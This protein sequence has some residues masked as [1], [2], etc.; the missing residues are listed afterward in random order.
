MV[1]FFGGS[2]LGVIQ[3]RRHDFESGGR[4]PVKPGRIFDAHSL[5][6][7]PVFSD[8][9]RILGG[10]R[11]GVSSAAG[12][13]RLLFLRAEALVFRWSLEAAK[14]YAQ[15]DCTNLVRC[16]HL[17]EEPAA[18]V[19]C[20]ADEYDGDPYVDAVVYATA[21]H[22]RTGADDASHE[23]Y[24]LERYR[25]KFHFVYLSLSGI[26]ATASALSYWLGDVVA[27]YLVP[28]GACLVYWPLGEAADTG[29]QKR[30]EPGAS[31]MFGAGG[32]PYVRHRDLSP[33]QV[34]SIA[35]QAGLAVME[36]REREYLA[37]TED[38]PGQAFGLVRQILSPHE[39]DEEDFRTWLRFQVF[40]VNLLS[41][42]RAH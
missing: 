40:P 1:G 41:L 35:A 10:V 14:T 26:V 5:G 32:T 2:F 42:V 4:G 36:F 11:E 28:G 7:M 22:H 6:A 31:F 18:P 17:A 9:G 38:L 33:K 8:R 34:N 15:A 23:F 29:G 27:K 16:V 25:E 30:P 37:M 21:K 20:F 19:Y 13:P 3:M 39:V 24:P 12:E